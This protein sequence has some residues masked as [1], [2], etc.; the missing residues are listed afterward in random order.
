MTQAHRL[1]LKWAR[2][3][4]VYLTLFG[5]VLLLFFALTGFMLNHEDWFLP[6]QTTTGKLPTDLLAAPDNRDAIIEKLRDD[7]DIRGEFASFYLEE[8]RTFR[9]VFKEDKGISEAVIQKGDGAT[10]VTHEAG[11]TRAHITIMEGT[12]PMDLLVPDD[13]SK[14]LP[15]VEKLRKDYAIHGEA[16]FKYE[17]ESEAFRIVFKAPGYRAEAIIQGKDGLTKVT[18]TT[19]GFAGLFLDLHRGKDSGL[20]WSFVIDGVSMLFLFVSITG[21]ILWS[22]LRSRAQYGIA[23][24]LLG[25]AI[26]LVVYFA[27]VPR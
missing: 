15:I 23:V 20:P 4:H 5:F 26:G 19:S 27:W 14:K 3:L 18:H 13:D 12:M 11:S 1:L 22:S 2:T 24:L 25:L 10:V 8:N 16:D 6:A 17:K 7:F 9:V 21:L